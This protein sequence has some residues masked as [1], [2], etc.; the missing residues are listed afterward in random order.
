MQKTG[1]IEIRNGKNKP[2]KEFI[3]IDLLLLLYNRRS[4]SIF[5]D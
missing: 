1:C 3:L 2:Y 5:I 4:A